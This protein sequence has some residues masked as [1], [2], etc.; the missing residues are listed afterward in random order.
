MQTGQTLIIFS[1]FLAL[2]GCAEKS[3][4]PFTGYM[5]GDLL[6]VGAERGGRIASLDTTEGAAVSQGQ[7]L[8]TI[9]ESL[10]RAEDDQAQAR[11]QEAE[12]RLADA[13][14]P[15]QTN[16]DVSVLY[17]A[18]DQAVAAARF[19]AKDYE[20]NR[21]LVGRG[22]VSKARLDAARAALDRDNASLQQA[23]RR[24]AQ[25]GQ[26]ARTGQVAA[27]E[28]NLGQARA[29]LAQAQ[30]GRGKLRV[31]APAAGSIEQLYFRSGEVV[32][33]GQ[34][35]LALLP[36]ERLK[37]RFF[38]P[39][40]RLAEATNGRQISVSCDSCPS[41]MTARISFVARTAEFTPPVIIARGNRERLV[42]MVEATPDGKTAALRAG[43][44]VE[45]SFAAGK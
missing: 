22:F 14:A 38:L 9:D 6:L 2:A 4:K 39:E 43:Q 1:S 31:S 37:V 11:V 35:V 17:A 33:V 21:A 34:P 10:A 45:A 24:I 13:R 27:A 36:P 42:F 40:T 44:P 20:R 12:A 3:A 7:T 25:A 30:T 29:L 16:T 41:G 19:S 26:T 23:Q 28:A 32:G 8:F 18:R 5:E 15:I